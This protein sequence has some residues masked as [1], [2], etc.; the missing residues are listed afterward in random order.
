MAQPT[1]QYDDGGVAA[2]ERERKGGPMYMASSRGFLGEVVVSEFN[3][4]FFQKEKELRANEH[5]QLTNNRFY[6]IQ[7]K[8]LNLMNEQ[9]VAFGLN[10]SESRH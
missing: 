1:A 7:G 4:E 10:L 3:S 2:P 9:K 5:N 8:K 6:Y